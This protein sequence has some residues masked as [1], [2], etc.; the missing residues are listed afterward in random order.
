MAP[1]HLGPKEIDDLLVYRQILYAY[2]YVLYV[3]LYC[4][5]N[6]AAILII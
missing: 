3:Q 2:I 6:L 4:W 5:L 1:V